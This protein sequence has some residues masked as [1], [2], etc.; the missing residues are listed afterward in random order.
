MSGAVCIVAFLPGIFI[1]HQNPG[2]DDSNTTNGEIKDEKWNRGLESSDEKKN[3]LS[4]THYILLKIDSETI[5]LSI[6]REVEG[7]R[8]ISEA[9]HRAGFSRNLRLLRVLL[10]LCHDGNVSEKCSFSHRIV[11]NRQ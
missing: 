9:R 8:Q 11:Y 4:V 3:E 6:C 10:R 5:T 1:E 7:G 2:T